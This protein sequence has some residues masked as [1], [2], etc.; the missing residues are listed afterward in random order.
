MKKLILTCSIILGLAV[1]AFAKDPAGE[2]PIMVQAGF[3]TSNYQCFYCKGTDELG[4]KFTPNEWNKYTV[5]VNK[6]GITYDGMGGQHKNMSI[7]RIKS[8]TEKSGTPLVIYID[9]I[10]VRDAKGK[11]I[12][13]VDFEDGKD[14]GSYFTQGRP[15][16]NNGKVVTKDG[17]KCFMIDMKTQNM[18]GYN[19]IEVQWNLP[20]FSKKEPGWNMTSGKFTV[21]YEYFI[22]TAE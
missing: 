2:L 6:D 9:N 15:N 22:A 17:R 20:P 16:E 14:G 8:N 21:E 4:L 19:S 10:I 18:Y 11:E 12:L 3:Y 13:K 7:F 5:K 1:S